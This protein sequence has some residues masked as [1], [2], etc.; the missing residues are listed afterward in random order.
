MRHGLIYL[1]IV[2]SAAIAAQGAEVNVAVAANFAAPMQKIAADFERDTG[3]KTALSFGS[4]GNFYNQIKSGAP[5]E[6]LLAADGRTPARLEVEGLAAGGTRFT[7]AIGRLA[8]WSSQADFVDA[9]GQ[10]LQSD[11]FDRIALANPK[12][13]PYGAA[14][15]ETLT[16]LGLLDRLQ[17]KFVQGENVAQAYQFVATG[18]APLGFVALA[19]I[20]ADGLITHGSAWIVPTILHAPI[21]QDAVLLTNGMNNPA[22]AALITYLQGDTARAIICTY[23][24]EC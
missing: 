9:E 23:G 24:Y 3:Y 22:A 4:T 2:C 18:N 7:Y 17:T 1:F 20:Y 13:A 5:F 6:L 16:R 11:R 8:L 10:V 21:Q 12:L 19:Q 15:V 14:A